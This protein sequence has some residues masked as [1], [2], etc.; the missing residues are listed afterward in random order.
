MAKNSVRINSSVEINQV[1]STKKQSKPRGSAV[2]EEEDARENV[3]ERTSVV[4]KR[5]SYKKKIRSDKANDHGIPKQVF[6]DLELEQGIYPR[7]PT[8]TPSPTPEPS[9]DDTV[10]KPNLLRKILIMVA[11]T[12]LFALLSCVL[13]LV[14]KSR[15]YH[16][17]PC[18]CLV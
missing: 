12:L 2:E 17:R 18:P 11:S 16:V 10:P 7:T 15:G 14:R 8:P 13:V 5:K 6:R 3:V 4:K 9:H 1:K